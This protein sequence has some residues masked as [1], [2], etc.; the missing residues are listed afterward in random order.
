MQ[1]PHSISIIC[2]SKW[3]WYNS[4]WGWNTKVSCTSLSWLWHL[5]W[6]DLV[7]ISQ[8][9]SQLTTVIHPN[10]F[11]WQLWP[12]AT[13]FCTPWC[14]WNYPLSHNSSCFMF[15]SALMYNASPLPPLVC[16]YPHQLSTSPPS[17]QGGLS[18]LTKSFSRHFFTSQTFRKPGTY[19][20][21]RRGG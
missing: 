19:R 9:T 4:P 7:Y 16:H 18:E 21:I 13:T 15:L 20:F 11:Q 17:P 8:Y 5:Y 3:T 12:L 1:L 6:F 14:V 2:Q 10:Q